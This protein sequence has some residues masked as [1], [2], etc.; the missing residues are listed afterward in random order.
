MG[1]VCVGLLVPHAEFDQLLDLQGKDMGAA[2]V[3]ER[4][5]ATNDFAM[6]A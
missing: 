4:R 6:I 3:Y 5:E 1:Q 2:L